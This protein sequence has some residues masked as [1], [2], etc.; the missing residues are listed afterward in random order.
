MN[1]KYLVIAIYL[2]FVALIV[3]MVMK[4]CNQKVELETKNYYN[5]EL[6]FQEQIDAKMA[7][8]AYI[9]SFNVYEKDGQI[10]LSVP[11][12]YNADSMVLVFKKPDDSMADR[13]FKFARQAVSIAK[14]EFKSGYYDLD[15]RVYRSGKPML[16]EKKIKL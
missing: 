1:F 9:D 15:I 11:T 7:G 3:M 2:C 5:E 8:N 4:S 12:A 16:I 14:S 6:K 10:K 13:N